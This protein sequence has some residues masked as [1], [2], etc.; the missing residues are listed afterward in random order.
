MAVGGAFGVAVGVTAGGV[1]GGTGQRSFL[2]LFLD[3]SFT[4]PQISTISPHLKS[5]ICASLNLG[6]IAIYGHILLSL[7]HTEFSTT[8]KQKIWH[9]QFF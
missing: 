9:R 6:S 4:L 8:E 5:C 7:R 1:V 3:D 2:L